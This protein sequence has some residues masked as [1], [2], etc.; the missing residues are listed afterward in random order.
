[1]RRLSRDSNPRRTPKRVGLQKVAAE[2]GFAVFILNWQRVRD[3]NSRA[4]C[5]TITFPRCANRPLWQ[6]AIIG[7][8][9]GVEPITAMQWNP[10]PISP[11][12]FSRAQLSSWEDSLDCLVWRRSCFF[13]VK[14]ALSILRH[15]LR[16]D[17]Y[18]YLETWY[19]W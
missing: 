19:G 14:P 18:V 4:P 15:Y 17:S 8:P 12:R 13:R 6:L 11:N 16:L 7:G 2:K 10:V 5:G 3:S 9:L 1:M